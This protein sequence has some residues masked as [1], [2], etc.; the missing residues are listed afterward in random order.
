MIRKDALKERV[1]WGLWHK[2]FPT[3]V[4]A[5]SNARMPISM[6][7]DGSSPTLSL[8]HH[9]GSEA[10]F[11]RKEKSLKTEKIHSP[12]NHLPNP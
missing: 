4:S 12:S 11:Q 10:G 9:A 5:H 2:V 7:G 8:G 3:G 1:F 6:L